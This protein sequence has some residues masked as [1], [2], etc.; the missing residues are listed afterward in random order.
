CGKAI[1]RLDHSRNHI[2]EHCKSKPHSCGANGAKGCGQTFLRTD[3]L[4]RHQK[5]HCSV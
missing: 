4:K 3:D 2:R 5:T 1:K